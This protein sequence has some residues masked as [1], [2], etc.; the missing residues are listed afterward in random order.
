MILTACSQHC[1]IQFEKVFAVLASANPMPVSSRNTTRHRLNRHADWQLNQAK[2]VIVNSGMASDADTP[3]ILT[4]ARRR[5]N[6]W[7]IRQ[8]LKRTIAR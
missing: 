4:G 5:Q 3:C 7:D 2:V 1:L 6:Q 8:S